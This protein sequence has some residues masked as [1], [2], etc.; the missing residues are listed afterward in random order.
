MHVSHFLLLATLWG[1]KRKL[2]SWVTQWR[3]LQAVSTTTC[4]SNWHYAVHM[5]TWTLGFAFKNFLLLGTPWNPWLISQQ[6]VRKCLQKA[7]P[8]TLGA[9][10]KEEL[11]QVPTFP[12]L[13]RCWGQTTRSYYPSPFTGSYY[14]SPF[15][16]T[17]HLSLHHLPPSPSPCP[18]LLLPVD[19]TSCL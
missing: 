12:V 13:S 9:L 11:H 3:S 17:T 15:H 5:G 19:I 8:A 7:R 14:P 1:S 4:W 18:S 16:G 6:A 2:Q 10:P